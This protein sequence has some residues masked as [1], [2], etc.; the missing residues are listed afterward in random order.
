MSL[1]DWPTCPKCGAPLNIG[2]YSEVKAG[3]Q[4]CPKCGWAKYI[5]LEENKA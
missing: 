5:N 3:S 1:F 2:F 4:Q